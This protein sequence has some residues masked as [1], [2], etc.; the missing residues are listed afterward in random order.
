M[1]A[2][3]NQKCFVTVDG[4]D[5]PIQEP[6]PFN[7]RWCSHKI[8]SAAL[9][10]EIGVCLKTGW[11]VWV[12]GPFPAGAYPDSK[13]AAESLIYYLDDNECFVAD[14][15]Y[16]RQLPLFTETLRG[17]KILTHKQ[18]THLRGLGMKQ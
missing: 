9:R 12:N 4:T 15:G 2:D 16:S 1:M 10:Y 13:I 3:Y 6:I 14:G 18:L 7:R 11:I 8:K 17:K 5:F